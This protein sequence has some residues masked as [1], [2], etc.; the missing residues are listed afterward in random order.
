MEIVILLMFA[1]LGV[2]LLK[3][4]EQRR[5]IALLG[6]H[7]SRHQIEKLM[8][9]L[10]Q[11]YLRA[12]GEDDPERRAQIWSMLSTAETELSEQ[13]QRFT[14][15]FAKVWSDQTLVSTLP[16]AIPY[17]DKLF[18]LATFDLRQALA[19]HAKGI[20][21]AV[22]NR[23][24]R[25]LRDKAFTLSAEL[26]LMQHSC[27]WFCR[28]KAIASARMLARHQTRYAQLLSSVAPETRQAYC[29]LVGC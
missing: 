19:I 23:E 28:S 11:G 14:A 25:S 24:N 6:S 10:T 21:A 22:E 5:R 1:A 2:Q 15:E 8:E 27:H 26:F 7:L 13:F 17:A 20:A 3:S 9:N 29:K 18:P 16:I 12:L 4:K